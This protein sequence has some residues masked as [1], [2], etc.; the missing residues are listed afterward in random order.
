MKSKEELIEEYLNSPIK[1][2]DKLN[3]YKTKGYGN[4][5]EKEE[6]DPNKT[7]YATVLSINKDDTITVDISGNRDEKTIIHRK[8]VKSKHTIDIGAD[9]FQKVPW[10]SEIRFIN[11]SIESILHSIGFEI[12]RKT[13]IDGIQI[14]RIDWNPIIIDANQREIEYQRG[15]VWTLRDKQLLIDS[16]Y[17]NIEIGKIIIRNRSW[18]YVT[19]R[20]KEG[21]REHI[22][23]KDVVD[24][25]QRLNAI[26][27]FV[28]NEFP[29][30]FG[31]F[32]K[33]LSNRAQMKFG[34]F[35][36][37][38]Y[39]EMGENATDQDVQKVFLNINFTGVQM[40][41]DHIDFVKSINV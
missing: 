23:F 15:F 25:K 27:G 35:Q 11:F 12:E 18:E 8:F 26:L 5:S 41:Q 32:Y 14:P 13:I 36:A 38:S 24:G 33:D 29:D 19:K 7:E 31:N 16:I 4:Y 37:L 9:P 10:N 2:G 28:T 22:A 3:I 40:S 39:G 30:S 6:I 1:V 20:V 17:N 21:K 34:R